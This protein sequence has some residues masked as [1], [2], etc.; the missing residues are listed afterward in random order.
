[1]EIPQKIAGLRLLTFVWAGYGLVWIALEGELRWVMTMSVTTLLV[2][3][4]HLIQRYGGGRRVEAGRWLVGTAVL[5]SLAGAVLPLLVWSLMALKTGL[6]AH[7]PEFTLD[8]I[9][10]VGTQAVL[11]VLVG[12][13]VGGG[14]GLITLGLRVKRP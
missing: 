14:V 10:W 9:R 3:G 5:G 4:G 11:W 8:E 7:G 12:G 1:M 2:A 13:L 6:H